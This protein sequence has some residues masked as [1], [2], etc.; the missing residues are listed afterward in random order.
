MVSL[1]I[2]GVMFAGQAKN[3]DP[4]LQKIKGVYEANRDFNTLAKIDSLSVAQIDKFSGNVFVRIQHPRDSQKFFK[5]HYRN[6]LYVTAQ[7]SPFPPKG[8]NPKLT[9]FL[10]TVP[11]GT[12][13]RV[14]VENFQRFTVKLPG[15]AYKLEHFTGTLHEE[16]GFALKALQIVK[17]KDGKII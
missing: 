12:E 8:E 1:V 2:V 7:D 4:R 3:P 5:R 6:G 16:R 14:C 15:E 9:E 11:K 13:I 10:K 17:L